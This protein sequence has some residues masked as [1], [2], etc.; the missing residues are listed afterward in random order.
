[1]S[2]KIKSLRKNI[3][4]AIIIPVFNRQELLEKALDS[5]LLQTS[6]P[7]EVIIVD[8]HSIHPVF[9]KKKYLV[10]NIKLIRNESNKG[11]CFSRNIGINNAKSD[12]CAFLDS[13]DFYFYKKIELQKEIANTYDTNFIYGRNVIVNGNKRSE[14]NSR[15]ILKKNIYRDLLFEFQVPNTSTLF[16]SRALLKSLG[17][18]DESLATGEDYDLWIRAAYAG[19]NFYYVKNAVSFFN[20]H[21]RTR[22]S[23]ET[24]KRFSSIG[25]LIKNRREEGL[26]KFSLY[27]FGTKYSAI[28]ISNLLIQSFKLKRP[29]LFLKT[30]TKLFLYPFSIIVVLHIIFKKIIVLITKLIKKNFLDQKSLF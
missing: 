12:F 3:T 2:R 9:I 19:A 1:M 24:E 17:G 20:Q 15:Y 18:F 10:L 30:I 23:L 26:D 4:V 22:L 6:T 8:D 16:I 14:T 27:L 29:F 11:V 28:L 5:I 7:E 21:N 25:K 13:D